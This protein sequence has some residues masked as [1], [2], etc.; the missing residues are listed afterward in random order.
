MILMGILVYVVSAV[1]EFFLM[2]GGLATLNIFV[3]APIIEECGK[4]LSIFFVFHQ[5]KK[6]S[7]LRNWLNKLW[8]SGLLWNDSDKP[9]IYAGVILGLTF[10]ASENIIRIFAE[11]QTL[12]VVGIRSVSVWIMHMLTPIILIYGYKQLLA[13]KKV[14]WLIYLLIA[15]LIHV[16]FN[17]CIAPWLE[18]LCHP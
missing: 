3:L 10:A 8:L 13:K 7:S 11:N 6:I 9:K 14:Q 5:G 17:S 2:L 4:F 16:F 18:T 1:I 15:I 12:C